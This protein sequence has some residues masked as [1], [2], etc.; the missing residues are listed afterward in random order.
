LIS[1]ITYMIFIQYSQ[2]SIAAGEGNAH[3]KQV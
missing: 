3:P 1:S 2:E